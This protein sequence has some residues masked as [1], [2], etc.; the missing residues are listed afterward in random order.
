MN[1]NLR[2]TSSR[3]SDDLASHAYKYIKQKILSAE[4]KPGAALSI[5]TIAKDLG[6]SRTPI[7]AACQRLEYDGLLLIIPKQGVFVRALTI[8][9]AREISELRI[10]LE[11]Y[12]AKRA[13]YVITED[14]IA[15]LEKGF[16]EMESNF[17]NGYLFMLGD[18]D[19]H[20]YLVCKGNNAQFLTTIDNL[21]DLSLLFGLN[22]ARQPARFR[23]ILK[24][25]RKIIDALIMK[26][27][28]LFVRSVE[29]NLLNGFGR[30]QSLIYPINPSTE[31]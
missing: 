13:F 28:N 21:Y 18:I 24:E 7:T 31:Y 12:S 25:H 8:N 10:A 27:R 5:S 23:E 29:I 3:I 9:D 4:L 22:S 15:Y 17:D 19:L 20:R 2:P 6:I 26:D 1:L 11:T 16:C 14:D 30:T